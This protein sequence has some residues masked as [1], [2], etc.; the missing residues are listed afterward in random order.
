M[1]TALVKNAGHTLHALQAKAPTNND[2]GQLSHVTTP[3]M[4]SEYRA[5]QTSSGFYVLPDDVTPL[6]LNQS[7]EAVFNLGLTCKYWNLEVREFLTK[8]QQDRKVLREKYEENFHKIHG[9]SV[10]D[11]FHDMRSIEIQKFVDFDDGIAGK[12]RAE[13]L[14]TL[15]GPVHLMPARGYYWITDN[16]KSALTARGGRLTII[17]VDMPDELSIRATID[18]IKAIPPNGFVALCITSATLASRHATE[19]WR[20]ISSHP[21]VGHISC[22]GDR[23]LATGDN[24]VAWIKQLSRKNANVSSFTLSNCRLDEQ[25]PDTLSTL[26]AAETGIKELEIC[27]ANTSEENVE[28]LYGA[29]FARNSNTHPKLKVHFEASNLN[30]F[31]DDYYRWL[32]PIQCLYIREPGQ[33]WIIQKDQV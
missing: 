13:Q 14:R 22:S 21:V 11:A 26:L 23:A 7:D 24:I 1:S 2:I 4:R 31:I 12:K 17:P 32:F 5:A 3:R 33:P 20:A 30:Q 19:L 25:S 15:E 8:Q 6:V 18:A 27:E 28:N 9:M 29:V 10:I 16:L